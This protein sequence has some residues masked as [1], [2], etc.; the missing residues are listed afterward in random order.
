MTVPSFPGGKSSAIGGGSYNEAT[1]DYSTVPGGSSN[2][3]IGRYS[4]AAGTGAKANHE[5]SFVWKDSSPGI[6]SSAYDDQFKVQAGGGVWLDVDSSA[7][8]PA[9]LTVEAGG[10]G[11]VAIYAYQTSSDAALVLGNNGTGEFIKAFGADGLRFKVTQAGNVYADGTFSSPANDF[12]EMLPKQDPDEELSPGDIIGVFNGKITKDTD[13]VQQVLVVSTSPLLLGNQSEEGQG[14]G[15]APAA[16]L[17]QVPV[18]VRGTVRAGDYIL[19]SGLGDG[20]GL[21]VPADQLTLQQY[22]RVVGRAWESSE[23]DDVH[24]VNVAVGLDRMGDLVENMRRQQKEIRD[25]RERIER[26]EGLAEV[27]ARS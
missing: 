1:G 4:F 5:G 18:K 7:L 16:F 26:L 3:A 11:A 10:E 22:S 6:A 14:D 27:L 24:Q 20:V 15:Y 13:G 12:A 25:L 2:D 8:F 23:G 17:G 21:A 19:P 9:G